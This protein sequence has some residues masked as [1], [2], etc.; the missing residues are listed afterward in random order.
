VRADVHAG[1]QQLLQ[2][3]RGE[4]PAVAEAADDREERG[5]DAALDERGQDDLEVGTV[6]TEIAT[7]GTRTTQSRSSRNWSR[8]TQ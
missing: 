5:D 1:D 7:R 8:R 4:R 6:A 3:A 2:P